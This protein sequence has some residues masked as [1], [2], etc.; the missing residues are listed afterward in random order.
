MKANAKNS[1]SLFE[2]SFPKYP[3]RSEKKTSITDRFNKSFSFSIHSPLFKKADKVLASK[4]S[5]KQCCFR[6]EFFWIIFYTCNSK[7]SRIVWFGRKLVLPAIKLEF[8]RFLQT[9]LL[10][11]TPVVTFSERLRKRWAIF[12]TKLKKSNIYLRRNSF[13]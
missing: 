11:A 7:I 2:K 9:N 3:F 12:E 8:A 10:Y 5:S 6:R 1:N 4:D 13:P